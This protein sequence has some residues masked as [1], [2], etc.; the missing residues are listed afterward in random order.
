MAVQSKTLIGDVGSAVLAESINQLNR[1]AGYVSEPLRANLFP[2]ATHNFILG[3]FTEDV[4][5]TEIEF[6]FGAVVASLNHALDSVAIAVGTDPDGSGGI[7]ISQAL[8]FDPAGAGA[9]FVTQNIWATMADL[10]AVCATPTGGDFPGA[11]PA[12]DA[13]AIR[14]VTNAGAGGVVDNSQTL[15]SVTITYRPVKDYLEVNPRY[16]KVMQNFSTRPR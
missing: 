13:L 6:G 1:A 3:K 12:G 5:I 15:E 4:Y 7:V 10:K 2:A 14:F 9:A 8:N 11:L 16:T